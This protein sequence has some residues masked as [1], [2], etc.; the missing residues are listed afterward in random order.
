MGVSGLI[1]DTMVN[2]YLRCVHK[3]DWP[4]WFRL[5]FSAVVR[6]QR[7]ETRLCISYIFSYCWAGAQGILLEKLRE[8]GVVIGEISSLRTE[9]LAGFRLSLLLSITRRG[10]EGTIIKVKV[11]LLVRSNSNDEK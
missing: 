4:I 6:A 9:L 7:K 10:E 3:S 8:S 5:C 11:Y 1:P 2:A